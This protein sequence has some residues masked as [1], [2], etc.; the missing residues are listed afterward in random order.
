MTFGSDVHPSKS[1]TFTDPLTFSTSKIS[2]HL[3]DGSA[4]CVVQIFIVL[5]GCTRRIAAMKCG[6]DVSTDLGFTV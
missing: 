5:R 2:Q 6:T 1:A 4:Q 3:L